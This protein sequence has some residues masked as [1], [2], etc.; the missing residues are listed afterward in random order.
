LY[1][2][3]EYVLYVC[4]CVCELKF[5][6]CGKRRNSFCEFST[7]VSVDY[8]LCLCPCNSTYHSRGGFNLVLE[9]AG[10]PAIR[11]GVR[12][13]VFVIHMGSLQTARTALG[14][15]AAAA[16]R[17]VRGECPFHYGTYCEQAND[18][19]YSGLLYKYMTRLLKITT[20]LS[21][22]LISGSPILTLILIKIMI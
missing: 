6:A 3:T 9:S 4:M 5:K 11:G 18:G 16:C 13:G 1:I 20:D 15:K 7:R 12:L 21:R 14:P 2:Q 17:L 8:T 10:R 22:S 19:N